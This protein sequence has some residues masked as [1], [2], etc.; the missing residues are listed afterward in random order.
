[1]A[2]RAEQM[3]N[4]ALKE[5][6]TFSPSQILRPDS[7][8]QQDNF[9]VSTEEDNDHIQ[10]NGSILSKVPEVFIE[11]ENLKEHAKAQVD[12]REINEDKIKEVRQEP[13]GQLAD[14]ILTEEPKKP[15]V[16]CVETTYI[17]SVSRLTVKHCT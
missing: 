15:V 16:G 10:E 14:S 7:M 11:E 1:M 3:V 8:N 9:R 17:N 6:K 4:D 13:E 2:L 5:R 12:L